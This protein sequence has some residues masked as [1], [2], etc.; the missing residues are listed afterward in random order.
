MIDDVY[1]NP[2]LT[3]DEKVGE[4]ILYVGGLMAVFALFWAPLTFVRHYSA[5]KAGHQSVFDLR[6]DL[7]YRILRMSAAFF[8]QNKSGSI[9]S[10]LTSDIELTQNLVGSAL[11]NIWMDLVSLF[12]ILYFLVRIDMRV[13]LIALVT[14]PIYLYFFRKLRTQIKDTTRQVQEEIS[15]MAGNVQEKVAGSR[16]VHAFTQEKSEE[17]NFYQDANQVLSMTMR[18][19]YLQGL[20][21]TTSGLIVQ[22]APLIVMMYGGY[23]VIEETLTVGELVAVGMYLTP[24]YT[25][26]QR[27][28]ELNVVF[29]NAMAALDRVFEVMDMQPEI[30]DKPGAI[31]LDTVKGYVEFN[32]VDFTYQNIDRAGSVLR[33]INFKVEPGHKVALVGPSGAGKSTITSLIPRFYDVD[34]GCICI[35]GQDV[36]DVKLKSLRRHVGMVLQ[37]PILFSGTIIDNIRYGKPEATKKEIIAAAKAANAYDFI[38]DLPDGF[39]TE[40]GEGGSFLS[41]GQRQRV[42]IARA[43]LKNPKILILD[44]ATSSLDSE[45]EKLI[46]AAL[47]RLMEDKTTFVIAHRLSTIEHADQILVLENGR[48]V[49]T[50]THDQLLYGEGVYQ[51]LYN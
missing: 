41:G 7:Y 2:A 10:R 50:G 5:G 17:K 9:V 11:T 18:R 32:D 26:L 25:P 40:V 4:L 51:R 31:K 47:E 38:L 30:R 20:N 29:A 37:T 24:L 42:T 33:G 3:T 48:I 14:F 43:F 6:V 1:L 22:L 35:D 13:M 44:E 28:S 27:F 19:V 12:L 16:V 23:R 49:E 15:V 46:Q 36:R 8:D 21:Q 39:H 45:S 34:S